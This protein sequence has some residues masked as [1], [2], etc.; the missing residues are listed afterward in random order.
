MINSIPVITKNADKLLIALFKVF[1]LFKAIGIGKTL[2]SQLSG[3]LSKKNLMLN[4]AKGL[5]NEFCLYAKVY[6]LH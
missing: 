5:I 2:V 6:K 1:T 3:I 4:A